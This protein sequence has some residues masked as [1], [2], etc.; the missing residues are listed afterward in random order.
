MTPRPQ[1][2]RGSLRQTNLPVLRRRH[3]AAEVAGHVADHKGRVGRRRR[4]GA[5]AL[6]PA[7]QH[8]ARH[9]PV[10]V[11]HRCVARLRKVGPHRHVGDEDANEAPVVGREDG[12]ASAC[13]ERV[14]AGGDL[15][16]QKRGGQEKQVA[17]G[18]T[19]DRERGRRDVERGGQ[20]RPVG[21][22][23]RL[24]VGARG[25]PAAGR[26][27]EAGELGR[28]ARVQH[29]HLWGAVRATRCGDGDGDDASTQV[30]KWIV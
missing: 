8:A 9:V 19:S 20:T 3:V 25:G 23:R 26:R 15:I 29:L 1:R 22:R 18:R 21:R 17:S 6:P 7:R 13:G 2:I 28:R 16:S 10:H 14:Q 27:A 30:L 5:H 11:V 4:A 24:R 12:R